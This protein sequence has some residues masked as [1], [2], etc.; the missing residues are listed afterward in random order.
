MG[1]QKTALTLILILSFAISILPLVRP[2]EDSWT[3]L[4]PMPTARSGI[5]VA[6]VDG[7]IYA[8]V[9]GVNYEYDPST[10]SWTTKTPMPTPRS[11][12]G[13]AVVENKY[14]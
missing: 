8:I 6:V 4:E 5:G 12:F 13:I 3:T 7:K 9:S 1:E 10:G 14:M 2:D 11:S